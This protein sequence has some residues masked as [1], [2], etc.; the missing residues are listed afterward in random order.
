MSSRPNW[1]IERVPGQPELHSK[2][3][4]SKSKTR[5]PENKTKTKSLDGSHLQP[6]PLGGRDRKMAMDMSLG[7]TVNARLARAMQQEYVSYR[8]EN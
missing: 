7:R 4:V 5:I 3:P 2:S 8:N 6:L 1:S